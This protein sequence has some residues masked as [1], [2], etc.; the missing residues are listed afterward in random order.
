MTINPNNA[1]LS[2]LVSDGEEVSVNNPLPVNVVLGGGTGGGGTAGTE[3]IEDAAAPANP[4]GGLVMA[5]RRDTL[6]TAEVSTDGDVVALKASNKGQLHVRAEELDPLL[7]S[8]TETAPATDTASSGINGRLQRIAQRLSTLSAQHPSALGSTNASGSLSVAASTEDV[9]RVGSITETAPASDTAS[10][11]L[12]GRLQRIAQRITS[13]IALFPTSLGSKAAASSFAVT[14]STE[15][16]AKLGSVTETAPTTDTASSGLNGRLQR[17]SQRLTSLIALFP[18]SLGTKAAASSFS[19]TLSSEDRDAIDA[20]TTETTSAAI[21]SA[22]QTPT[23]E[24]PPEPLL[25]SNDLSGLALGFNSAVKQSLIA[26]STG[27]SVRVYKARI[28]VKGA[29]DISVYDGDPDSGGVLLEV[30]PFGAAG[31]IV[32][33]FDSRSY[34]KTTAGNALFFKASAAVQ[35]YGRLGYTQ[36]A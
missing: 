26:G 15:D 20:L 11:G 32:L 19:V 36:V 35:V 25:T 3:Y 12:N 30:I 17:V 10:S 16:A 23:T 8:I 13:L 14:V 5:V 9:A 7:G 1:V 31:G 27:L 2:K 22:L 6:T 29:T 33:D 24:L 34:W 28:Y 4:T 18:T 21:L